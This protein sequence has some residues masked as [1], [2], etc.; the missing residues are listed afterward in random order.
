MGVHRKSMN[1]GCQ[2]KCDEQIVGKGAK[3]TA[4]QDIGSF[5]AGRTH[6]Q[7]NHLCSGSKRDDGC[8]AGSLTHPNNLS[9]S[10]STF[11]NS[12]TSH[13]HCCQTDRKSTRLTPVTRSSR[14]PSSA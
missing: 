13:R 3:N 7:G 1:G 6:P 5:L 9:E 14:M 2:S 11:Y 8:P 12:S 10:N 4:H